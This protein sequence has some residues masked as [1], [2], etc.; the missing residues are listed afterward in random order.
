MTFIK[1]FTREKCVNWKGGRTIT[2]SGYVKIYLPDHPRSHNNY[3]PEHIIIAEKA[4]GKLLPKGVEIHHANGTKDSGA[5]VICQDR[6]YHM[7]LHQR[8]RAI[9][10]CGHADWLKCRYCGHY[11]KPENMYI[12]PTKAQWFHRKCHAKYEANRKRKNK[13]VMP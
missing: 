8:I 13:N 1:G 11:D 6:S 2:E 5:L 7:M 10:A 3:V 12:H 4:L 9:K